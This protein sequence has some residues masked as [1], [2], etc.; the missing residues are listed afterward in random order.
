MSAEKRCSKCGVVKPL[1]AFGNYAQEK[2]GL[3]RICRECRSI[4]SRQY[5]DK[6]REALVQ[7]KAAYYA[8]NKLEISRKEALYYLEHKPEHAAY[9]KEYRAAHKDYLARR[10]AAYHQEHKDKLN[11]YISAYY[12][13]HRVELLAKQGAHQKQHRT[14]RNAYRAKWRHTERGRAAMDAGRLNRR[15]RQGGRIGADVIVEVKA[16]YNGLCPYCNKPI[17]TGHIDHIVPV[18]RGGTNE[19]ENLVYACAPCNLKKNS[20]SLLEFMLYRRQEAL[21]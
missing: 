11:A 18:S 1:S 19:R 7:R 3:R 20:H 8:A 16:E 21:V 14:E 17:A 13:E 5:R 12:A 2:D 6:H 15:V 10:Y 4:E 9:G